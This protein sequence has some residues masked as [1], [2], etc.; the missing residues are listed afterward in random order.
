VTG[1]CPRCG[2]ALVEGTFRGH[3]ESYLNR[4]FGSFG[5]PLRFA[6][7]GGEERWVWIGT[8]DGEAGA[9]CAD[10]GAVVLA[11]READGEW[12]CPACG[13]MVPE[14]FD[15]CWKCHSRRGVD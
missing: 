11:G 10:C 6:T 1:A 8:E 12:E 15:T 13:E 2:G 7:A 14:R 4:P 3:R 9:V 5:L